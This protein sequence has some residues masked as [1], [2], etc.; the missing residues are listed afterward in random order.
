MQST[1]TWKPVP[2]CEGFYDVSS[3]GRVFSHHS[4]RMLSPV[5]KMNG[6]RRRR[7]NQASRARKSAKLQPQP[8]GR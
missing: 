7:R 2:G 1:E 4:G 6:D 5:K 3:L 8:E